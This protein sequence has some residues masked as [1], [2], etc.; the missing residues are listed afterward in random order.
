MPREALC[1]RVQATRD[2]HQ[3]PS[4]LPAGVRMAQLQP[5]TLGRGAPRFVRQAFTGGDACEPP[6]AAAGAERGG[7]ERARADA[8]A[9][10]R[11]RSAELW[12][13][14]PPD[15]GGEAGDA[16]LVVLEPQPC[17]YV[18]VLWHPRMCAVLAGGREAGPRAAAGG[19]R[20]A[21]EAAGTDASAQWEAE[22][23]LEEAREGDGAD[24][25]VEPSGAAAGRRALGLVALG[26]R[27]TEQGR[28]DE[29]EED[30]EDDRLELLDPGL[31]ESQ[32]EGGPS[33]DRAAEE[34]R[35][36]REIARAEA[37]ARAEVAA[38]R[39]PPRVAAAQQGRHIEL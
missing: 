35:G 18:L 7:A 25:A 14:C 11:Q 2:L 31:D 8:G 28:E 12:L 6:A 13:G 38:R 3:R 19:R 33:A 21:G 16:Y 5:G 17:Q 24:G 36:L 20:A 29:G 26:H 37:I 34:E 23:D 9:A 39:A 22:Q 27:G 15:V 1:T 32:D 4:K 30:E 10:P